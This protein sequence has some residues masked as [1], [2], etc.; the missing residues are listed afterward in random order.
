MPKLRK[1]RENKYFQKRHPCFSL[2]GARICMSV[3]LDSPNNFDTFLKLVLQIS[4]ECIATIMHRRGHWS[5]DKMGG[6]PPVLSENP[7]SISLP[8]NESQRNKILGVCLV[9]CMFWKGLYSNLQVPSVF[10]LRSRAWS[11][12]PNIHINSNFLECFSSKVFRKLL[13]IVFYNVDPKSRSQ[14]SRILGACFEMFH[15]QI[16]KCPPVLSESP[17]LMIPVP[18]TRSQ[19]D[20]PKVHL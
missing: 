9:R 12:S 11:K 13:L 14:E 3:L 19:E 1:P 16:W 18:K 15:T 2:V 20:L 5:A 7:C 17:C 8:K 4:R 6:C 10:Y